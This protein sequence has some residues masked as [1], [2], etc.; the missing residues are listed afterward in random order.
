METPTPTEIQYQEDHRGDSMAHPVSVA[1][2]TCF[3]LAAIAVCFRI[4]S[5]RLASAF[6]GKDDYMIFVALVNSLSLFYSGRNTD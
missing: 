4:L 3:T 5:R 2:I 6:L 1:C